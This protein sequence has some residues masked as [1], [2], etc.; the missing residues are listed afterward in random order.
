MHHRLEEINDKRQ[1]MVQRLKIAEKEKEGLEGKKAE[2]ELF[3]SKQV[4]VSGVHTHSAPGYCSSRP[5]GPHI[6]LHEHD[7]FCATC[8]ICRARCLGRASTAP[9]CTS[10]QPR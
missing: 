4:G 5:A 7:F 6:L 10:L 2:A 1:T 8:C 9:T 3:L